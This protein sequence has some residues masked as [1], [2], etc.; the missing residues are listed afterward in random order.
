MPQKN[1]TNADRNHGKDMA[2]RRKVILTCGVANVQR[3]PRPLLHTRHPDCVV[4]PSKVSEKS[5]FLSVAALGFLLGASTVQRMRVSFTSAL[6]WIQ[7][8]GPPPFPDAALVIHV[9]AEE[10]PQR[11]VAVGVRAETAEIFV[12]CLPFAFGDGTDS[13]P[14]V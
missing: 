2:D 13:A 4:L 9:V 7:S 14:R 1:T 3:R 11:V 8:V 5:N 10:R 6:L 12:G